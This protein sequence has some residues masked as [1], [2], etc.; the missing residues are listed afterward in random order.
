MTLLYTL[1]RSR[2]IIFTRLVILRERSIISLCYYYLESEGKII[3][4]FRVKILSVNFE[5]FEILSDLLLN[6]IANR[7]KFTLFIKRPREIV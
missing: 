6:L 5:Y 7:L 1:P 3:G 4:S 2:L